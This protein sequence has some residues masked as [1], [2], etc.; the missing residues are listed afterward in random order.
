M[1]VSPQDFAPTASNW[2]ATPLEYAGRCKA[3]FTNPT[4]SVEGSAT[5]SVSEVGEVRVRM[6]PE[7]DSLITDAHTPYGIQGFL[8]GAGYAWEERHG[9]TRIDPTARNPC[10]GLTVTTPHG[11]FTTDDVPLYGK[12]GALG[13]GGVTEANFEV[14]ISQFEAESGLEAA[15][16]VLPLINFLSECRQRRPELDRHPLR[17]FPTLEVPDEITHVPFGPD[18]DEFSGIALHCLAVANSKNYLIHFELEEGL[19][20]VERLPD[21]GERER[22]LLEGNE[23]HG[24]TA[25]MVGPV[26]GRPSENIERLRTWFS[27]DLLSLLTLATGT[28]V[29]APWI[30]LRDAE[31]HL[32]RRLHGK[33][34]VRPFRRG[35]RLIEEKPMRGRGI[36]ATGRLIECALTRSDKFGETFLRAAIVHL[37]RARHED[38]SLDDGMSHVSR[39]LETL[40]KRFELSRR[41]LGEDLSS[42]RRTEVEAILKDAQRRLRSLGK[43]GAGASGSSSLDRI[44]QRARDADKKDNPFGVAVSHLLRAFW[45]PDAHIL[46]QHHRD[47]DMKW[48]ALLSHYRGDVTHHGYLDIFE[49]GHDVYEIADVVFHLHDALA[50]IILKVLRFDGGYRPGTTVHNVLPVS[51]DWVKPHF[52]AYTLGY[53]RRDEL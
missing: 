23:K 14:G 41:T 19:G 28:E 15:Y 34:G 13:A 24:T 22:L 52:S 1:T 7:A 38:R 30:E 18:H 11:M 16:W 17:V 33:F 9:V 12:Q 47:C 37:V 50:R 49:A 3:E 2:F 48:G 8:G 40:C 29:G 21:Y 4:G 25:V 53:G 44:A 39:G 5:V 43:S 10:S 26:G 45:L 27:F 20:F 51:V 36:Q 6:E 31:G 32:V 42:A 35:R 46:E